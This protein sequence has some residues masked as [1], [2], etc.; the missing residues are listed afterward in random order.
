MLVQKPVEN[1]VHAKQEVEE[2]ETK[3][4]SRDDIYIFSHEPKLEGKIAETFKTEEVGMKEQGFMDTMKNVF[5][6]R[7]D[8]LRAHFESLGVSKS[9]AEEL[10]SILDQ[11]KLVV[12]AK[13]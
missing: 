1:V 11:G 13:K 4:Y 5:S 10:E 6:K 9:D 2:L 8:E 3:G 7:G 12:I